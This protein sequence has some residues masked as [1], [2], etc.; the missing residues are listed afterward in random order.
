MILGSKESCTLRLLILLGMGSPICANYQNAQTS[1]L[2]DLTSECSPRLCSC[3]RIYDT[4]RGFFLEGLRQNLRS[5]PKS[6]AQDVRT[7]SPAKAASWR[8]EA[9]ARVRRSAFCRAPWLSPAASSRHKA[10]SKRD[11]GWS[12]T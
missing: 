1:F 3:T 8:A 4:I 11:P 9:R 5:S 10:P 7:N 6:A 12:G 2:S